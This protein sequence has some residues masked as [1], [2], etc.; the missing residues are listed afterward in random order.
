MQMLR[1]VISGGSSALFRD[2]TTHIG[3]GKGPENVNPC[4]TNSA[5]SNNWADFLGCKGIVA[6]TE[7]SFW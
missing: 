7:C 5:R 4:P 2:A 6:I 3:Y 1:E